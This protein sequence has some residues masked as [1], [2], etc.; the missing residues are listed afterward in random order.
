MEDWERRRHRYL[1]TNQWLRDVN[2][3]VY[4][5]PGWKNWQRFRQ[6]LKG[7]SIDLKLSWIREYWDDH[8][9]S[10]NRAVEKIRVVN[11]LG[12]LLRGGFEQARPLFNALKEEDI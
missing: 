8:K 3:A 5:A 2:D 12:A 4:Y 7:M 9:Y 1:G 11:Y 6:S 10:M